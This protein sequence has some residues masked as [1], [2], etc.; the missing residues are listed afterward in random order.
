LTAESTD[1]LLFQVS[2]CLLANDRDRAMLAISLYVQQ[3]IERRVEAASK[4]YNF[5]PNT[6]ASVVWN[7][8][9]DA[10]RLAK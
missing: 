6:P 5:T 3:Q 4:P 8:A 9:L 7:A 2:A 1:E 10:V